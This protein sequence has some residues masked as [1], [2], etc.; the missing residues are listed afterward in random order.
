MHFSVHLYIQVSWNWVYDPVFPSF[1][2][3]CCLFL[4]IQCDSCS[5]LFLR[6]VLSMFLLA[7][8]SFFPQSLLLSCLHVCF[9]LVAVFG[10]YFLSSQ[11]VMSPCL[12]LPVSLCQACVAQS[13][14]LC[15][16][17][18]LLYLN[19]LLSCVQYVQFFLPCPVSLYQFCVPTC[20]P[21]SRSPVWILVPPLPLL[22]VQLFLFAVFPSFIPSSLVS[23]FPPGLC[24][25][26]C[27]FEFS[28][29]LLQQIKL[30]PFVYSPVSEF[31]VWVL[32]CLPYSCTQRQSQSM[33]MGTDNLTA[34]CTAHNIF[35]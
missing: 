4:D 31:C 30:S 18:F 20:C 6:H 10:V 7:F 26:F 13:S 24:F 33:K 32:P 8:S 27:I 9:S 21:S 17:Y 15:L 3:L 25:V 28:S 14:S 1:R 5:W 19:S 29:I 2:T 23:W 34:H 35:V 22:V 11:S 16:L 12:F